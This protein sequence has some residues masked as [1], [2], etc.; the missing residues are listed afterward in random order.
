[1]NV[2]VSARNF[3]L[4]DALR[5]FSRK[6]LERL[7]RFDP[8]IID[9]HLVLEKDKGMS[10]IELTMML[11]HGN[12]NSLVKNPDIYLGIS[13]VVKKVERQ[14]EKYEAR[15]RERKRLARKTRRK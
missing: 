13:D 4:T 11:K 5:E 6:K 14:L 10:I 7:E 3:E 12:V 2:T 9:S 15:F 8:Y 1:M